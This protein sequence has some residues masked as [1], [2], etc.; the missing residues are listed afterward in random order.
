MGQEKIY[1]LRDRKF[2]NFFKG[3]E[4]SGKKLNQ[5][6]KSAWYLKEKLKMMSAAKKCM[7]MAVFW[8][9]LHLL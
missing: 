2:W 7:D 6:V 1:S 3:Q 4:K 8:Y 9:L 5:S